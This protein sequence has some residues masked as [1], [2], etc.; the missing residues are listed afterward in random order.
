MRWLIEVH[1][2]KENIPMTHR[3]EGMGSILFSFSHLSTK[4][5]F[6]RTKKRKEKKNE[7]KMKKK[8]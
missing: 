4:E 1:E 7:K 3:L 5:Y 8:G 2:K 6:R